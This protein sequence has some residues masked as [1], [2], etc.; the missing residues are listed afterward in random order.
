[1]LQPNMSS[2]TNAILPTVGSILTPEQMRDV[3]RYFQQNI[4]LHQQQGEPSSNNPPQQPPSAPQQ[5]PSPVQ[6]GLGNYPVA[7]PH[8][9]QSED[10]MS[11][12]NRLFGSQPLSGAWYLRLDTGVEVKQEPDDEVADFL[13][14]EINPSSILHRHQRTRNKN[15]KM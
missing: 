1:M 3:E 11:A 2:N 4:Q 6:T 14:R 15:K 10:R 12:G 9:Q 13:R 7:P 5:P 8:R